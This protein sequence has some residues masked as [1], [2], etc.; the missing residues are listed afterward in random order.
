MGR[1]CWRTN[2]GTSWGVNKECQAADLRGLRT[3]KCSKQET[4]QAILDILGP[5]ENFRDGPLTLA[6]EA[7]IQLSIMTPKFSG[8][9]LSAILHRTLEAVLG[10][11][12][13]EE[14]REELKRHFRLLLGS[15]LMEAP[16]P[17]PLLQLLS[18]LQGYDLDKTGEA[19][20]LAACSISLL[21][22]MAW[23]FP[24]LRMTVIQPDLTCFQ[25]RPKED[26]I[27]IEDL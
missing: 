1:L 14:D 15:L 3:L 13:K 17:G 5:L 25:R 22:A 26:G 7:L 27:I 16:N 19:Q 23:R 20:E 10:G 6:L 9:M 8:D 24:Q 18:D 12:Q 4:A 11:P 2:S 21:L